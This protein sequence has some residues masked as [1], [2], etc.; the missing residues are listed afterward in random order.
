MLIADGVDV[1]AISRRLG[2]ANPSVTLN[3]F[4]HL[5]KKHDS[6]VVQAIE[7]ALRGGR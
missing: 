6:A 4:G 7:K 2:H 3:V 1:V 5:F